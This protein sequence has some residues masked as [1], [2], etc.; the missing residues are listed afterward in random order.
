MGNKE[1]WKEVVGYEGLYEVSNKGNVRSLNFGRMGIIKNLSFENTKYGYKRVILTK[2]RVHK[3][4]FVH[5]L[6]AEAFIPNHENKPCVDHI[7]TDRGNNKVENLQWVT[8]KENSNNP[9]SVVNYSNSK[10]GENNPFYGKH[11]TA[12]R[13]KKMS[14]RFSGENNP[15]YGKTHNESIRKIMS[16]KALIR[17]MDKEFNIKQVNTFNDLKEEL[18]NYNWIACATAE[19]A[20]EKEPTGI[21]YIE[22]GNI[23]IARLDKGLYQRVLN[24]LVNMGNKEN[25]QSDIPRGE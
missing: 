21:Y 22:D 12:E 4:M 7:N 25:V 18:N 3:K 19:D 16:Q 11:H 17:Q 14:E 13:N 1:I 20:M 9:K 23:F 15:F 5:R 6:V 2:N 8:Q 24:K 10:L